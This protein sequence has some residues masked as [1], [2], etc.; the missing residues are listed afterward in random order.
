MI[1][2]ITA[3]VASLQTPRI[4]LTLNQTPTRRALETL[5]KSAGVKTFQIEEGIV[6]TVTLSAKDLLFPEALAQL[7]QAASPPVLAVNLPGGAWVVKPAPAQAPRR[8]GPHFPVWEWEKITLRNRTAKELSPL[9]GGFLMPSQPV[10]Q[11][12]YITVPIPPRP[13]NPQNPQGSVETATSKLI[14]ARSLRPPGIDTIIALEDATL[15]VQGEPDDVKELRALIQALDVPVPSVECSL[16]V[17]RV[18]D[19]GKNS[20]NSLLSVKASGKVGTEMKATS[21]FSGTPAQTSR[22]DATFKLTALGSDRYEVESHC[23]L[24]LPFSNTKG[25]LTRLEKTFSNTRQ[26]KVGQTLMLD[27]MILKEEHGA[28]KGGE[29]V[30]FFLTLKPITN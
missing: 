10:P 16:E 25:Q 9:L 5:F 13:F 30:L 23:E 11:Q 2:P 27:G 14:P 28:T 7:T 19:A 18:S 12:S 17:V 6:G 29:E 21:K 15:L 20:R 8:E 1:Y 22:L 24:S 4:S 3:L 26:L